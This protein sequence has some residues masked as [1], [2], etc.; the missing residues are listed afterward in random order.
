MLLQTHKK[1]ENGGDP[2]REARFQHLWGG[3]AGAS[4]GGSRRGS[5]EEGAL[6][7]RGPDAPGTQVRPVG[8][9][10]ARDRALGGHA[11]PGPHPQNICHL[12]IAPLPDPSTPLPATK[13]AASPT[14]H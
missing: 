9:L 10:L 12:S 7:P 4:R 8:R 5:P 1:K 2:S 14:P 13:K 11:A 6:A 3:G